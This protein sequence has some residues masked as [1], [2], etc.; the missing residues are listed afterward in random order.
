MI[1]YEENGMV[2]TADIFADGDTIHTA[3]QASEIYGLNCCKFSTGE[4]GEAFRGVEL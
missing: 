1:A 2:C 4:S 3:V